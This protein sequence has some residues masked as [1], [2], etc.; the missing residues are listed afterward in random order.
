MTNPDDLSVITESSLSGFLENFQGIV[1]SCDALAFLI[2]AGCS[3]CAELPLTNQLTQCVL[4]SDELDSVS[5]DILNAVKENFAHAKDPNIEDFLSEIVDLLAIADRRTEREAKDKTVVLDGCEYAADELR[6]ASDEI[7]QAIAR[8]IGKSVNID[9]HREFVETIHRP[10]R[11]GRQSLSRPVDYLILNY[12]TL[13]EDALALERISYADGFSGG[14]SAW[15]DPRTFVTL[16]I[17]ARVIKLHGSIDWHQLPDSPLP[18]RI[19]PKIAMPDPNVNPILIWPSSTKYQETQ[20][21]P[22]AQL[23]DRGR[24]AMTSSENAQRLLVICGYSF[25]DKHINTEIDK[26]LRESQGNLTVAAFTDRDEPSEQLKTWYLDEAVREQVLIFG[27]KGF[28][29][30]DVREMA[31]SDVL[32]WKFE[33]LTRILQGDM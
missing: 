18:R 21:D 30:G 16:G 19:N 9:V 3:F 10:T 4:D 23:M 2:G 7:K 26:A 6:T 22:F 17:S 29:H 1:N 13:I 28:F 27:N 14:A 32:W 20:L 25:S 8:L 15:W 33:N 5:Q 12:D 11:V 24:T 31:V